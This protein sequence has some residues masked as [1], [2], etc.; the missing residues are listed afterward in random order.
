M[1][2]TRKPAIESAAMKAFPLSQEPDYHRLG[3]P[4]RISNVGCKRRH[5]P[6]PFPVLRYDVS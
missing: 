2:V 1:A 5:V 6:L 3:F 4:I